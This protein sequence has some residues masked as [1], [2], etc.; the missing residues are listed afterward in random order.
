MPN[1]LIRDTRQNMYRKYIFSFVALVLMIASC[2]EPKQSPSVVQ[3][4]LN[5]KQLLQ[6]I[7]YDELEDNIVFSVKGDTVFYP[8]STSKPVYFRVVNDSLCLIGG[9]TTKY[10]IQKLTEHL[11]VFKNQNGDEV[12]LTKDEDKDDD[13]E[14]ETI[15]NKET[16]AIN[17]RRV[18]KNDTVVML[19]N[20]RNHIYIQV[21]P[22]TYK[23]LKS[24]YN[25]EGVRVDNIYYDNTVSICIVKN[26]VKTFIHDFYKKE[27]ANSVPSEIIGQ[28]ILND[29]IFDCHDEEGF[30]FY[31][32]VGIPDSSSS[33]AAEIIVTDDNKYTITKIDE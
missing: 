1:S 7:W 2:S 13:I 24:S 27:F 33:Y 15:E 22:T 12:K 19:G 11:F 23:V 30:H 26:S 31:A 4:D 9:V 25:S 28:S 21:N 17:Q 20:V 16:V 8:D 5:A 14:E 3:E 10:P 6:G 32:Q 18:I 29:I